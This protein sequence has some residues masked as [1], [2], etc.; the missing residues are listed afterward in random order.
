MWRSIKNKAHLLEA[1]LANVLYGFPSRRLKVIAIT[2]TDGKTTTSTLVYHVLKSAGKNVALISTVAAFIGD[3]EIDTGFH[4]TNPSPFALQRLLSKVASKGMEYVVLE[5]TSHGIDQNRNWGITPEVAAITNVTHEHLDY[6]KTFDNYLETKA[7]LLVGSGMAI[8]NQDAQGSYEQL[9]RIMKRNNVEIT[10]VS[11]KTLPAKV[12][13]AAKQRFGQETYNFE[14][15]A[16]ALGIAKAVGVNDAEVASALK[17]FPGV[18]GRMEVIPNEIGLQ[19]IVDFAHTPNAL[20]R[21][22]TTLKSKTRSGKK[23]GRLI[24]IFGCAG[25]RDVTK[26]PL[27][28]EIA[29]RLSDLTVFTAE[30]PRTEDIWTIINQMKSGVV[31]GH[32]KIVSIED[33]FKAIEFAIKKLAQSGDVILITG[34]GHERSMNLGHGETPWSDQEAVQKIL[35]NED[36]F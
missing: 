36:H 34:K 30:D 21:A 7:K 24:S 23:Q 32:D 9:L 5:V 11:A 13:R 31:R 8:L 2:G 27:M 3:E 25:L 1:I 19:I 20:E 14:N 15:T 16:I 17:T 26:R 18:K 35:R 29:S 12:L 33:R 6:H 28:G 4:V 22:L 10:T